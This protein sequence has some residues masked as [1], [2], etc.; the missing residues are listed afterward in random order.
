[1]FR[2]SIGSLGL[3]VSVC[4]GDPAV[5]CRARA[6]LSPERRALESPLL[7]LDLRL[8]ARAWTTR[9]PY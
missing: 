6:R 4:A 2:Q 9:T 7:T 5:Y 8:V 3:M 1:M